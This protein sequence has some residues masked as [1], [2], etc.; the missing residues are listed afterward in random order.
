MFID[1][2]LEEK[3]NNNNNNNN[4]NKGE[5]KEGVVQIWLKPCDD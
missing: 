5:N 2:K 3:Y 1:E 4:N